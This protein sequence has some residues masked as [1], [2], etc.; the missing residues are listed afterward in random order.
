MKSG[1]AEK[2][3]VK[4]NEVASWQKMTTYQL[5]D[6]IQE[7]ETTGSFYLHK[8]RERDD[9]D[10]AGRENRST[11]TDWRSSWQRSEKVA[12]DRPNR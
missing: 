1:D 11:H 7:P 4:T 8:T 2:K 10:I 12:R 5:K 9:H 3:N 6:E